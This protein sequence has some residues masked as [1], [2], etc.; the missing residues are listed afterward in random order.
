[1]PEKPFYTNSSVGVSDR[2]AGAVGGERVEG[3]IGAVVPPLV[4]FLTVEICDLVVK[5]IRPWR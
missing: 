1:M 4:T 3:G 2:V 5:G